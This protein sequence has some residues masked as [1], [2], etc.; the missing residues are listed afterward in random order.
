MGTSNY[1]SYPLVT[2]LVAS[3]ASYL[4]DMSVVQCM[5]SNLNAIIKRLL[6]REI[7]S[8]TAFCKAE[9]YSPQ[10]KK[11]KVEGLC[12]I[13]VYFAGN[14]CGDASLYPIKSQ[15]SVVTVTFT[16]RAEA[17]MKGFLLTYSVHDILSSK[18]I[19]IL[20]WG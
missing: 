14:F 4:L 16:S 11:G 7:F 20:R 2:I 8:D 15:G 13:L 9:P 17:A 6:E 18:S 3:I 12:S 1:F 10:E 5:N 19:K